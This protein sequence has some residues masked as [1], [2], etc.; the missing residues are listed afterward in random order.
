[1]ATK[2]KRKLE[3]TNARPPFVP[4]E[5]KSEEEIIARRAAY[6]RFEL[7]K[8][9]IFAFKDQGTHWGIVT[10]DGRKFILDKSAVR[11]PAD[12]APKKAAKAKK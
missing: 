7:T 8:A 4:P 9:D 2:A 10:T 12:P 11:Q 5:P 1:V 6:Q 3:E